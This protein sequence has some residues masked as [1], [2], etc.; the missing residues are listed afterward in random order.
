[1]RKRR[2]WIAAG[3]AAAIG[4][5]FLVMVGPWPVLSGEFSDAAYYQQAL[6]DIEKSMSRHK[7]SP[8]LRRLR[9]GWGQAKLQPPAGTPLAGYGGRK[10]RPSLGTH[11][12]LWVK[13]VAVSDGDDTAVL[14]GSDLLVVT[15]GIAE[16]ARQ[17]L[18]R[19]TPLLAD[20]LLFSASHLRPSLSFSQ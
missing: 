15:P 17:G 12:D 6:I 3:L 4:I 20:D 7:K 10:G 11:D 9:A 18:A 13:A 14:I 1:M 5:L 16:A 8:V 2:G 19:E